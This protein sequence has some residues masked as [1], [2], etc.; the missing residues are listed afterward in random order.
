MNNKIFDTDFTF[1]RGKLR[2][3]NDTCLSNNID[4]IDT[5]SI[6]DKN[7]YSDHKPCVVEIS[8]IPKASLSI[9]SDCALNTFKY[10]HYDINK[11]LKKP[12]QLLQ[13]EVQNTIRT[14]DQCATTLTNVLRN[15]NGDTGQLCHEI[16][17]TIY[18]TCMENTHKNVR[19][20][21]NIPNASTCSSGNFKAIASAN[22]K[23]Y[24]QL[25]LDNKREEEYKPYLDC[26]LDV[27]M[28][29]F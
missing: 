18:K 28:N 25:I 3:Q 8:T 17:N 19:T 7:V 6:L 9:V 27:L 29:L 16:T 13:L 1:F 2:S 20:A 10:D 14:L 5:F 4:M 22:F 24:E 23:M 11:R 12:V 15:S 26:W 21:E